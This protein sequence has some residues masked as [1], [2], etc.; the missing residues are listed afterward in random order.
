MPEVGYAAV[1]ISRAELSGTTLRLEGDHASARVSIVVDGITRGQ[2]DDRGRFKLNV[3]GYT[4]ATCRAA[5]N[6]GTGVVNVTLSGCRPAQASTPTAPPGTPTPTP[7]AIVPRLQSL[8]LSQTS[9][10]G[11]ATVTGFISLTTAAPPGGAAVVL[12]S[13]NPSIATLPGEA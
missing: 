9:V 5:V 3:S 7:P 10:I 4:S 13:T 1:T 2:A 11:G 6:D 12:G 8:G